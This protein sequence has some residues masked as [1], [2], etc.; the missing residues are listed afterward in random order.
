MADFL[1]KIRV[2]TCRT[3]RAF[4]GALLLIVL[5]STSNAFA[6][7]AYVCSSSPTYSSCD[8]GYYMVGAQTCGLSYFNGT[9]QAGNKCCSCP[10]GYSCPGG[11]QAP[12]PKATYNLNCP[13]G[14]N[15]GSPLLQR[16]VH[17]GLFV[18]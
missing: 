8:S 17:L 6:E 4:L 18:V 7:N 10:S 5:F 15:C 14:T 12:K 16:C 9:P 2:A 3:T 13:S 1:E 11:V